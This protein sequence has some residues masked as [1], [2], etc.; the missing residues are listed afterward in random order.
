M[1]HS[2]DVVDVWK[3][4]PEGYNFE[5]KMEKREKKIGWK[6]TAAARHFGPG[7]TCY[8]VRTEVYSTDTLLSD[9]C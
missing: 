3:I 1:D 8:L 7:W 9:P 2:R 4:D 6:S 5:A